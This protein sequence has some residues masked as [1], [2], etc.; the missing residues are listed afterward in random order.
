MVALTA[1]REIAVTGLR[2]VAADMGVVIAAG[3]IGK[4]KTVLQM[5]SVTGLLIHYRYAGI[6]FHAAGTVL[7]IAA[8]ILTVWS[9]EDYFVRFFKMHELRHR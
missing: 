4:Y 1:G 6:D 8:F 5:T 9:G 2:A 3:R 7:F